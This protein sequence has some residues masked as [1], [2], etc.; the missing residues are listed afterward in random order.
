MKNRAEQGGT[1]NERDL[2]VLFFMA[3]PPLVSDL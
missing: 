2:P 3:G 1:D